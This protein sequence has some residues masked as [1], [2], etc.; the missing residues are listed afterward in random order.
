MDGSVI[1]QFMTALPN[2]VA[3]PVAAA[4]IGIFGVV[5]SL[6]KHAERERLNHERD[7]CRE[8]IF[9]A[10]EAVAQA[11]TFVRQFGDHKLSDDKHDKLIKGFRART[12]KVHIVA[13]LDT[14]KRLDA[15]T[16]KLDEV[17]TKL[18]LDRQR[19][20]N[21]KA[22]LDVLTKWAC[23]L[24]TVVFAQG[25]RGPEVPSSFLELKK[26]RDDLYESKRKMAEELARLSNEL[27]QR[28]INYESELVPLQSEVLIAARHDLG[29]KTEGP[30]FSRKEY[31]DFI[32][33]GSTRQ[34][35]ALN[36]LIAALKGEKPK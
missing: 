9:A 27:T 32:S 4:L 6:R 20:M 22:D 33:Q 31:T 5:V 28:A 15:F 23:E 10:V 11:R 18:N 13:Q 8:V 17:I 24:D 7:M 1:M 3:G 36:A 16:E 26:T 14:I 29:F 35:N 30:K 19:M 34:Q 21:R 12:T 2:S 25:M